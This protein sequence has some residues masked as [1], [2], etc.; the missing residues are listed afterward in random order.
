MQLDAQSYAPIDA[1]P[2][3]WHDGRHTRSTMYKALT[4]CY[5][6]LLASFMGQWSVE[7][8]VSA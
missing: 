5:S 3:A 8:V 4:L 1:Q 2:D 6:E 7:S